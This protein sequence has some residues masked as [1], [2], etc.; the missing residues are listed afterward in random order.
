M[1]KKNNSIEIKR[2]RNASRTK[3][4]RNLQRE[5]R[6]IN[7]DILKLMQKSTIAVEKNDSTAEQTNSFHEKLRDWA[8]NHNVKISC[9]RDL[10]KLLKNIGVPFL[11]QDPRTLLSTPKVVE[12]EN[13]ANGKL[14]YSGVEKHLRKTFETADKLLTVELNFH[15]DGL[16]LFNSSTKQ[17]WQILGQIHG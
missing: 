14:W 5:K 2:F 6:K 1:A 3:F 10:L 8:L 4:K 16:Q 7:A 9:M 17:F 11:P 15:V 13:I 12:V